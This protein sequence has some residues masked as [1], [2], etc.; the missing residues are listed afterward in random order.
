MSGATTSALP[1]Q[2]LYCSLRIR[3]VRSFCWIGA[4]NGSPL[5]PTWSYPGAFGKPP[6]PSELSTLVSAEVVLKT[7][8][9]REIWP[10]AS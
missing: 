4:E 6:R 10:S 1:G 2:R 5:L 3:P 7:V 8:W 9:V